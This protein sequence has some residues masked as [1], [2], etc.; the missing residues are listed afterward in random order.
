MKLFILLIFFVVLSVFMSGVTKGASISNPLKISG[1][2]IIVKAESWDS[3]NAVMSLHEKKGGIWQTVKH[4]IPVVLG[5]KGLGWGR[6]FNI[7]YVQID[8]NAPVKRE[9]DGK[10]PAG[11]FAIR[12]AFGFSEKPPSIKLPYIKLTRDI[13]CVDDE[14]STQYNRI[15]DSSTVPVRDWKSSEKM[16]GIDVYKTGIFVEH[17]TE[18]VEAGCG[19][20][21]FLHVWEAPGKGTSGCTAMAEEHILFITEWL[22]PSKNPLF[23][24]FTAD[25]YERI[26]K[27]L[28]LP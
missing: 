12:Q 14:K 19:S 1:Q 9:G 13:E 8:K 27:D 23:L 22:D 18:K 17:N 6:S 24:Q 21:I 26:R 4:G 15:V 11:V 3:V 10:S 28:E 16:S 25:I 20:C 7:D 5:K 2:I